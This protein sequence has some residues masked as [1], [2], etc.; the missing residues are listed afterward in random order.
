[1]FDGPW[2][3]F[4]GL[5]VFAF[6]CYV[7]LLHEKANTPPPEPRMSFSQDCKVFLISILK[8]ILIYIFYCCYSIRKFWPM[9]NKKIS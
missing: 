3:G 9:F 8:V 6:L 2:G 4:I 1:M 7:A 5:I